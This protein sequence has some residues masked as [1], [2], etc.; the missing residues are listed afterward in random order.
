LNAE[1]SG[2]DRK[3]SIAPTLRETARA[4]LANTAYRWDPEKGRCAEQALEVPTLEGTQ[5]KEMTAFMTPQVFP[6]F[7]LPERLSPD[8][9]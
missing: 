8:V 1:R 3:S 6:R 5:V 9:G 4:Q 7:G 2:P